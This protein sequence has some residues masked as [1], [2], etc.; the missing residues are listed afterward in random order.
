MITAPITLSTD[1]QK[2]MFFRDPIEVPEP[3]GYFG[4]LY[5]L[6]RDLNDMREKTPNHAL[7]PRAMVILA[8][9]D[10]LAKFYKN[11][12][13][14]DRGSIGTRYKEFV[15]KFITRDDNA[16]S[17]NTKAVYMCRNA[18][19]HNFGWYAINQEGTEEYRF[20]LS[21]SEDNWIVEKSADSAVDWKLNILKLE[22]SFDASIVE[23]KKLIDD[24]SKTSVSFPSGNGIFEKYG[25]MYI[26]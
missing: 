11:A 19:L 18:L 16:K 7:W 4:T 15:G 1:Q 22:Q 10:L 23:Y 14:S 24:K 25:W 2:E 26:G 12:D 3:T 13:N 21:R 6:R 8:G 20:T 17:P 9:I 5:L